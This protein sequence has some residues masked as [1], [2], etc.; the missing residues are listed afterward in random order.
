MPGVKRLKQ[1]SESNSK[2]TWIRGHYFG[3][4]GMLLARGKEIFHVP[5]YC[6]LQDGLK[7]TGKKN[8]GESLVDKAVPE[9]DLSTLDTDALRPA[10][11]HA[12][13]VSR[14]DFDRGE[15]LGSCL[16]ADHWN[17]LF[18]GRPYLFPPTRTL[19]PC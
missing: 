12:L 17:V 5:I 4:I 11:R 3:A 9:N 10:A 7:G 13:E 1:E 18:L 6:Q 2:P 14:Y 8:D 15:P 16:H 19:E